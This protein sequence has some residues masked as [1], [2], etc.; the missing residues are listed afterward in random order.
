MMTPTSLITALPAPREEVERVVFST[1]IQNK[2]KKLEKVNGTARP[3][4]IGRY[5][6]SMP[7]SLLLVFNHYYAKEGRNLS[8]LVRETRKE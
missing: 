7:S 6:G 4:R 3:G 8:A 1:A 2:G 5:S